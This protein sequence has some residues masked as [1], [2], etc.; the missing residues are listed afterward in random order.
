MLSEPNRFLYK[1][2]NPIYKHY[3]N[4]SELGFPDP[5]KGKDAA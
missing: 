4:I 2:F 5:L 1:H 3:F